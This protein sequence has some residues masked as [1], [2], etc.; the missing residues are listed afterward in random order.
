MKIKILKRDLIESNYV[1]NTDCAIARALKRKGIGWRTI[2]VGSET[3]EFTTTKG[4]NFL[5]FIHPAHQLMLHAMYAYS[6]RISWEEH[7]KDYGVLEPK[8]FM[9][10]LIKIN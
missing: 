9:L 6:D 2:M 10:E 8:D 5:G 4:E 1:D 7:I 3:A